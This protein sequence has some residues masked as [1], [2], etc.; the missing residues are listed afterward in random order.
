MQH[1]KQDICCEDSRYS[2]NINYLCTIQIHTTA[3]ME[4]EKEH[5]EL[6]TNIL[7]DSSITINFIFS[8]KDEKYSKS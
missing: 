1:N 7:S 6:V 4:D 5:E 3:Q 8:K 2:F